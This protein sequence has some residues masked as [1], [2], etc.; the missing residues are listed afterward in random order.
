M[1]YAFLLMIKQPQQVV[2][3]GPD[4]APPIRT[5]GAMTT[6]YDDH[7]AVIVLPTADVLRIDRV[8]E[9]RI[10]EPTGPQRVIS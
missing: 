10:V 1:K 9:K 5:E 7:G 3:E 6:L 8:E 4:D 2:L